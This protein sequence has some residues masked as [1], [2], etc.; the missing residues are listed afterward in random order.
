MINNTV[1][2]KE[3]EKRGFNLKL[4]YNDVHNRYSDLN[5]QMKH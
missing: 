3:E 2:E 4:G 1:V 5:G